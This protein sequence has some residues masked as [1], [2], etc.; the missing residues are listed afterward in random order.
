LDILKKKN[1]KIAFIFK[2]FFARELNKYVFIELREQIR[3]K[4]EGL[5]ASYF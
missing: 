2:S 1:L 5:C 3:Q 4:R